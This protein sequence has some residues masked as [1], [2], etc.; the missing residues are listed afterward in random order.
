MGLCAKCKILHRCI[1]CVKTK[2]LH[3][4]ENCGKLFYL[5]DVCNSVQGSLT[6]LKR[7]QSTSKLC[8]KARYMTISCLEEELIKCG[9]QMVKETTRIPSQRMRRKSIM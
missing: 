2:D 3:I 8:K 1:R 6:E 5:C 4:C 7:H 9:I